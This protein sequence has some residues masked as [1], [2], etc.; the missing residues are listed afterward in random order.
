MPYPYHFDA[1]RFEPNDTSAFDFDMS[2]FDLSRDMEFITY[3]VNHLPRYLQCAIKNAFRDFFDTMT[4]HI[5]KF[6]HPHIQKFMIEFLDL[7]Q[8][9]TLQEYK[10][11]I[12][13]IP[14]E[15]NLANDKDVRSC[16]AERDVSYDFLDWNDDLLLLCMMCQVRSKDEERTLGN[17]KRLREMGYIKKEDIQDRNLLSYA[18]KLRTVYEPDW[19][20]DDMDGNYRRREETETG[21][22]CF[23]PNWNIFHYLLEWDPDALKEVEREIYC[24]FY[25]PLQEVILFHGREVDRNK[26]SI[27]AHLIDSNTWGFHYSIEMTRILLKAGLKYHPYELGLLLYYPVGSDSDDEEYVI[28]DDDDPYDGFDPDDYENRLSSPYAMICGSGKKTF[29][30]EKVSGWSVIEECLE[31]ADSRILEQ[32]PETHLYPFML[33]AADRTCRKLD[34]L[35]YLLRKDPSVLSILYRLPHRTG[36][37]KMLPKKRSRSE[38]ELEG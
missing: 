10:S 38:Q 4:A 21:Y 25:N 3:I 2:E 14:L 7:Q 19:G 33:A 35:Y 20:Y 5:Q 31:E 8:K 26:N 36:D 37:G 17:L 27:K 16:L 9:H 6:M 29:G 30:I 34:L 28:E 13:C 1:Y 24:G 18:L 11:I 12:S 23:E 32:D 15:P 22:F